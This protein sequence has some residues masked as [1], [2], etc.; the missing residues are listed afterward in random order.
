MPDNS[1]KTIVVFTATGAQGSS[2]ASALSEAGYKIRGLTRDVNGKS[3]A[4]LKEK[5]YEVARADLADAESYKPALKGAYGAFVNTDFW[6]IYPTKGQDAEAT[7]GEEIRQAKAALQAC[8]DAGLKHV[9]Y[10]SLDDGTGCVHWQ[11]KADASKWAR[12]AGIP[13]T[14]LVMTAYYENISRMNL[15]APADD[16]PG[17]FVLNLPAPAKTL[18]PGVPV[19]Q[20]GLWARAAFEDPGKWI[21]KD[22][23]ACTDVV[24]IQQMADTL[25]AVSGKKVKTSGLTERVFKSQ[26]YKDKIGEELWENWDLFYRGTLKRDVK[27]SMAE[28]PGSWNFET[29]AKNDA[30]IKKILGF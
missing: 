21:G 10:S 13:I 25:S 11:S 5:G 3:A 19:Q 4:G 14:S 29:W 30:G 20:T 26:E 7:K 16:E 22:I 1:S 12:S 17:T 2:V 9:V 8:K 24:T 28:A 18:T 6:S 23:Y 15:C 27:E